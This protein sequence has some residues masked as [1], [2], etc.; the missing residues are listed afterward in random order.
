MKR[1]TRKS[2]HASA[3]LTRRVLEV[4]TIRSSEL[5]E[6]LS[7]G[8]GLMFCGKVG[9]LPRLSTLGFLKDVRAGVISNK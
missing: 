2:Q 1:L 4:S 9:R 7:Y 8:G 5:N 6:F 3:C